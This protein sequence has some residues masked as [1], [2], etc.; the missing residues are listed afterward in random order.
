MEIQE[1]HATF[2]KLQ[3]QTLTLR[4][5]LNCI[6]APNESGKSTWSHFLRVMLYGV[7]TRDR[8]ITA[9]KNRFAPWNGAAM[10]GQLLIKNEADTALTLSRDTRRANAPMG[11]FTCTY[12]G[13][14]DTVPGIDGQNAGETL[15]GVPREVFERSAFIRQNALAV[16]SDAELERRIAALITTGEEDVSYTEVRDRLKKQ[17][18]RRKSNRTT[19]QIPALEREITALEEQYAHM[20]SLAQ[21]AESAQQQVEALSHQADELRAQQALW[22]Q[23]RQQ[24][25]FQQYAAARE[26]AETA[27][28]RAVHL[29]TESGESL[30][31]DALLTRMEGQCAALG[32]GQTALRQ[33]QSDA[34]AARHKAESAAARC[35][36]HPLY[37]SS[38]ANCQAK[39][40]AIT[41]PTAPSPLLLI[42]G[43]L[44]MIGGVV[45][46]ALLRLY[47]L[48][49]V[50]C[51]A[52]LAAVWLLRRKRTIS[53][54]AKAEADHAA[55]QTQIDEYL[56]LLRQQ[57]ADDETA[58]QTSAAAAGLANAQQQQLLTLLSYL[59][60]Y[61]P[62]GDLAEAQTALIRL[63]R[64]RTELSA[65]RQAM[66]E[67]ALRRDL[68][69]QH[70]PAESPCSTE[71]SLSPPTTPQE[72][73]DAQLSQTTA[74]LQSA[75]S[76]LDSLTG[77]L[78]SLG[79]REDVAAQL[80]Q[81]Q[82]QLVRL[83]DEYEAIALAMTVLDETN[84]TLQ[85]RFSPALGARAAEIFARLT[86]GR[87]QKVLL[88]RDFSLE[89]DSDGAQRSVQL[90]SQGAADQLYLAVRLA[91]CDMALPEEKHV[92]LVLDDALT[93]FDDDRLHAALDY[94]VEESQKRQILLFTCQKREGEY[95]RGR[96]NVTLLS[97]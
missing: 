91:I 41:A 78:R 45:C 24:A 65:A 87:Y 9:D 29:L 28:R 82:Q 83:Q 60:P 88:R 43:I 50:L 49:F 42:V 8:G 19:G 5:G 94:L 95:L 76:R 35:A 23:Y 4:P 59:H 3:S 86:G 39:L 64:Q 97:L 71:I 38:E 16:D 10:R 53:A 55:L 46:A 36:A 54:R 40:E 63:R 32:E 73:I 80:Q 37:P 21:Q 92:P 52:S 61:A 17:L 15:L 44:L 13:T 31:D 89:T 66:R 70:L 79:S 33:A 77:Q 26:A 67:T 12:T 20:N 51:G 57:E 62:A 27:E 75:R 1:M 11:Q 96:E 34:Q 22:Q 48:L 7:T 81:R 6:Y 90:L 30:P 18:N 84:T 74:A 58:A 69:R 47:F 25:A 93:S 72:Q 85:N 68:L 14:A 56:P 2:G